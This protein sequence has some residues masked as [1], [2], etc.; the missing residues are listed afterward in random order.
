[1][2]SVTPAPTSGHRDRTRTAILEAAAAVF[3]EQGPG[4]RLLDVAQRAGVGEATLYR[5]FSNR[6]S[7]LAALFDYAV[8]ESFRAIEAADLANVPVPEAIARA[9]RAFVALQS[10]FAVLSRMGDQFRD[11]DVERRMTEPFEELFR[12][13][14]EEGL[15]DNEFTGYELGHMLGGVIRAASELQA[16]GKVPLERAA[17]LASTTFLRG[18]LVP[19]GDGR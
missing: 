15:I 13:G 8:D 7:L 17:H 9:V 5:Y 18:V 11:E 19:P 1:M 3:A 2:A 16:D 14:A 10:K 12:R 6:H 4:G